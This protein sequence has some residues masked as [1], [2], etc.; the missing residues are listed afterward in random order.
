ML[1]KPKEMLTQFEY[2]QR[3]ATFTNIFRFNKEKAGFCESFEGGERISF[4]LGTN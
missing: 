1:Y 4:F 2:E 3:G